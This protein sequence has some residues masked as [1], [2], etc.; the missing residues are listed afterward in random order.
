MEKPS[1][2]V[3]RMRA[4]FNQHQRLQLVGD[5]T[6]RDRFDFDKLSESRLIDAFVFR[7]AGQNLPLR[8]GEA[9]IRVRANRLPMALK[10][11]ST[12]N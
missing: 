3:G 9:G 4:P 6:Q 8:S 7:E 1:A 10:L 2:A 5:A 11:L 12:P